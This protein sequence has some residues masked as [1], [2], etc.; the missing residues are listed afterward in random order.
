MIERFD[1][2][3]EAEIALLER[4]EYDVEAEDQ[5]DIGFYE[6]KEEAEK[7]IIEINET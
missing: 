5:R 1:T 7:R 2:E 4:W 3:E 6:T